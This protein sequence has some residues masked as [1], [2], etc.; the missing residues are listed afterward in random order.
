MA[1]HPLTIH[2]LQKLDDGQAL[3]LIDEALEKISEDCNAR[4]ET[5]GKRKVQITIEASPKLDDSGELDLVEVGFSAKTTVPGKKS[6][7]YPMIG[8]L[9]QLH[10]D[11]ANPFDPRQTTFDFEAAAAEQ[12]RTTKKKGRGRRTG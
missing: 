1:H 9:G 10:F 11:E 2:N 6:K 8:G 12:K 7:T 3:R 4:P 5:K